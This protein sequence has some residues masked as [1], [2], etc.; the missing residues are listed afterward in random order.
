VREKAV[1]DGSVELCEFFEGL[2]NAGPEVR[3]PAVFFGV[4][5]PCHLH[6]IQTLPSYRQP[7]C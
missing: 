4:A 2:E 1:N 5:C 6:C 7:L 3:L